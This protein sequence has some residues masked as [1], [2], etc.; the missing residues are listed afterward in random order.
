MIPGR[1]VRLTQ[2][3]AGG[4]VSS[5]RSSRRLAITGSLV[6]A[7]SG[8]PPRRPSAEAAAVQGRPNVL[9]IET[10]DQTLE[11]MKVMHNVNA[12]I[13][14]Q[15]VTFANSFVNFSLCCPSRATFLTGQYAHNH[16]VIDNQPPDGGFPQFESLHANNNLAVWL[17]DAGYYTAHDRQV[18]ERATT[19]AR[20]CRRAGR[21]GTPRRRTT[22]GLQLPDQRQRHPD[23][24]R[25]GPER[26]QAGRAD[27]QGGRLR[28]TA[29]RRS[30]SRS[31]SG[32]P[33]RPRTSGG[34][35][36]PNPPQNC[37]GTAKPAPR[38]AH[39]F[40]NEPL[41]KPP[42]FNEADV[43]DKPAAIRSRP[44]LN[45]SAD[46]RHPAQVPLR[47]RVTAV[48]RRGRQEGRQGPGGERRARQHPA[49]LHV[50]QRLLQ[51]RAPD[52]RREGA[53]STRSRSGCRSRCAARASRQGETVSDLAIN[54]DLAPTIVDAANANPGLVMDGRSLIPVAA[55]SGHRAGTASS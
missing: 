36:N 41:P 37:R 24:L 48:G 5:Q 28:R 23:P 3:W 34:P 35:P 46:R 10:D 39:A 19:N 45:A 17:Q 31:S 42:N 49:R 11:S 15:G 50:G 53:T 20:L 13:G 43:S 55:A 4:G 51:R 47:A 32:S 38:H 14:D 9:V 40:D 33:T 1:P 29:G 12:L 44:L 30:R 8:T 21:S 7:G 6:V 26:L 27:Q 22:R 2:L 16:G 25:P 52:P 18:P 54:A